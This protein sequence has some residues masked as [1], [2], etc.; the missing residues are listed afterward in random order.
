[1]YPKQFFSQEEGQG[2]VEYGLV[3]VLVAVVIII[4]LMLLGDSVK[5]TYCRTVHQ[6]APEADISEPC[7]APIVMPQMVGSGANFI[8]IEAEI[9]DPD[10]N[11]SNPYAAITKVEFYLDSTESNPVQTENHYR[12]CLGG[13][14]NGAP[15][16][17]YNLPGSLPNG[18]HTIIILAYDSDG[19]VGRANY[20]FTK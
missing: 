10:G 5:N 15:C 4:I 17:N 8:N 9:Y 19:N 13:G 18:R 14:P 6:I 11:Q 12:Y 7:Q 1:M 16:R 2:L 3:L 20:S